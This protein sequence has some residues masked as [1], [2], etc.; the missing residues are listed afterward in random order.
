[1][2]LN[3]RKELTKRLQA[4]RNGDQAA[5]KRLFSEV[6]EELKKI[7]G[8]CPG[9]GNF[10]DTMQ[11]TALVHEAYL[12]FEKKFSALSHNTLE[13]CERFFRTVALVMR[14]I[15]KDY[16]RKKKADKRGKGKP[17]VS[18]NLQFFE[19][20][21]RND[22]DMIDFMALDEALNRLEVENSRWFTVIIH[23]YFGRRST[24]ETAQLMGISSTTV[25]RDWKIARA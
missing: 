24:G 15:M 16:W 3:Q 12:H 23:K 1:M 20:H 17:P 19:D 11:P 18:C 21:R 6:Y 7:A 22:F 9:K 13:N 8:R 2:H 4:S 25:K 5:R 14:A 10:G